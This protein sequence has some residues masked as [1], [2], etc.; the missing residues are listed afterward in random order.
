MPG[1][2]ILPI[3]ITPENI[4]CRKFIHH[5]SDSFLN[6]DCYIC[7]C[8]YIILSYVYLV[9]WYY[10]TVFGYLPQNKFITPYHPFVLHRYFFL[11]VFIFYFFL[12]DK[13]NYY[14]SLLFQF[15]CP[16]NLYCCMYAVCMNS[17]IILLS[18]YLSFH[19]I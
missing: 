19:I 8:L 6:I 16:I 11:S 14:F 2:T 4:E 13:A 3:S 17:E 18:G 5:Y 15:V 10:F 1:S 9:I 12:C 7:Q